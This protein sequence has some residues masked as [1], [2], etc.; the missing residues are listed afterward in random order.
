VHTVRPAEA[1]HVDAIV[2]DDRRAAG[3]G[4]LDNLVA[5]FEQRTRCQALR[6]EYAEIRWQATRGPGRP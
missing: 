2:D 4:I 1:G 6:P 5:E 3:T